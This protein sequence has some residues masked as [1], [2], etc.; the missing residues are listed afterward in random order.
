MEPYQTRL[1]WIK[2]TNE[3]LQRVVS[4]DFLREDF[5]HSLNPGSPP[6]EECKSM[7]LT[8]YFYGKQKSQDE[9]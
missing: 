9:V 4:L 1:E 3:V 2:T 6:E 7:D 8:P 5:V